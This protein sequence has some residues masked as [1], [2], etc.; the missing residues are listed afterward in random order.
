VENTEA[1]QVLS[2]YITMTTE[3]VAREDWEEALRLAEQM[4][5]QL[6]H[7]FQAERG[8]TVEVGGVFEVVLLQGEQRYIGHGSSPVEAEEAALRLLMEHGSHQV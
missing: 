6:I 5:E 7:L 1:I 3:A 4:R 2:Q 8:D